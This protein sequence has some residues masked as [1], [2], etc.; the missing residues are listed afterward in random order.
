VVIKRVVAVDEFSIQS[1]IEWARRRVVI[2]ADVELEDCKFAG[3]AFCLCNTLYGAD[4]TPNQLFAIMQH[5][6]TLQIEVENERQK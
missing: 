2:N 6:K 1:L 4:A 5:M 3:L